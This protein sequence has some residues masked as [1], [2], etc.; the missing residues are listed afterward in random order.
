M[1]YASYEVYRNGE[2]I[3]AGYT[4]RAVC[5]MDGCTKEIDRGLA[6]LCGQTPGG[7]EF[8]CG[9]YFCADHLTYAQQCTPCGKK[10]DEANSWTDP[11]TGITYDLRDE[12][13]P[14][15]EAY[16]AD[17]WVWKHLGTFEGEVPKLVPVKLPER[18]PG[19]H[20]GV[21]ITTYEF[22]TAGTVAWRQERAVQAGESRG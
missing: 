10:A 3:E 4:V 14:P 1:G 20:L 2:R 8:G 15:G 17:G 22:E 21:A 6:Y 12:Y 9:G 18:R 11:A 5:E 13:L 16:K 7:D 19:G